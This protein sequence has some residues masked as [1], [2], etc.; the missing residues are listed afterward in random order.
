MVLGK[1]WLA[2]HNPAIDWRTN[3]L[4]FE[5]AGQQHRLC[6]VPCMESDPSTSHLT[7]LQVKCLLRKKDTTAYL[8]MLQR[9]EEAPAPAAPPEMATLLAE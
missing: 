3:T 5:H 2:Q 1:P 7:A 9:D 4:R 6:P 8:C